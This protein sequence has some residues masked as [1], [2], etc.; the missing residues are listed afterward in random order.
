MLLCD[1]CG[2]SWHMMCLNPK[3]NKVPNVDWLCPRCVKDRLQSI[4]SARFASD[5]CSDHTW[6]FTERQTCS[7]ILR[8]HP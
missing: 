6:T 3:L 1:G 4:D 8:R 5:S 7:H 2:T